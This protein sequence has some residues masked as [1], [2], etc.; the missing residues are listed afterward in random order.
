MKRAAAVAA[1]LGLCGLLPAVLS[2]QEPGA[3]SVELRRSSALIGEH[4][5]AT[6]FVSA[7]AGTEV[8]LTPGTPSWAGFELVSAESPAVVNRGAESLWVFEV[9][10]APFLPGDV[11]LSPT[12]AIVSGAD[13]TTRTLPAVPITVLPTLGPDDPLELTPLAAPVPI[14]G[15]ESPLLRPALV[16]AGAAAVALIATGSSLLA[17]RWARRA[18]PPT[19]LPPAVPETPGLATA[20]TVIDSDPVSAYRVMSLVVKTELARRYGLRATALTS[21]ELRRRLEE[22]GVDRWQARL[23]GG[24]LDECDAVI[25][26]GYRPAPERRQADLTMAREIV[27]VEA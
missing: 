4:L 10:F 17:R 6:I 11:S 18:R 23:V 5:P 26:A 13:V 22:R 19:A 3:D 24:L 27:E 1:V 15:A 2:A 9:V 14:D 12:V 7:P 21:T 16:L 25:Y 8:E 20:E